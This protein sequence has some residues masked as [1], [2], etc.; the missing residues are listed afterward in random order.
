MVSQFPWL[1]RGAFMKRRSDPLPPVIIIG[2]HRSGTTMI[3]RMLARMGL[4]VGEDLEDNHESMFFIS[5]NEWLLRQCGGRWDNTNA[6]KWL[7]SNEEMSGLSEEYLRFRLGSMP[8]RAYL[9]WRRYLR[10]ERPIP[11]LCQPWGW[12]DPRNTFNLSFWLRLF[13][14]A[15]VVHIYRNGV[16][17]AASLRAR[18]KILV[19]Q[20]RQRYQRRFKWGLYRWIAKQAGF[21]T[22]ARLLDLEG[23][24]SLWEEYLAE[25]FGIEALTGH[26]FFKIKYEEFLAEPVDGLQKLASFCGLQASGSNVVAVAAGVDKDAGE[27]FFLDPELTDF[28]ERVRDWK[29]MRELG[30]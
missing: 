7:T 13:P 23:C 15:R 3:A 21:G 9:G 11:G 20:A 26:S 27:R 4:F 17:V 29:W 1:S 2:M 10:G 14:D 5:C 16:A 8:A 24:F 22:S 12:K 30:Y 18:S 19:E 25:A 28:Y 6:M